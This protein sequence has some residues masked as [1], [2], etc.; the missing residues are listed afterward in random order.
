MYEGEFLNEEKYG[1]G[2]EYNYKGN[3]KFEDE[4]LNGIKNG[5]DEEYNK[6]DKLKF[7]GEYI[8]GERNGKGKNIIILNILLQKVN[9]HLINILLF[10]HL[11]LSFYIFHFLV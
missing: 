8:N 10:C 6:D 1:K 4:Y 7:I 2:K 3:L 11:L 5:K 9:Y